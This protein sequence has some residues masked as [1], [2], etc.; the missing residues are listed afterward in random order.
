MIA[1][2]AVAS[3]AVAQ[4]APAPASLDV[5]A[6]PQRL[7]TL[8]DHRRINLYCTGSGG[9]TVFLDGGWES[10]TASWRKVQPELARTMRVCSYDR[11][12]YGFSD[13]GSMPRTADALARDLDAVIN[14]SGEKGPYI[15]VAHSMGSFPARLYATRHPQDVAALILLDPPVEHTQ[16]RYEA[17]RPDAGDAGFVTAAVACS[18]AVLAG[19]TPEP[20][21][22][23]C[24]DAPS[25]SLPPALNAARDA[26]EHSPAFQ[27]T[28]LSEIQAFLTTD[29]DQMNAARRP[30]G[31]LPV[32]VITSGASATDPSFSESQN[33]ALREL[34]WDTQDGLAQLSARPIHR[35]LPGAS[36][37]IPS[38]HPEAVVAA[39]MEARAMITK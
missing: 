19:K 30:L 16:A 36:H 5:Y 1:T 22:D 21:A 20:G 10:T 34:Q 12:G 8:P 17:I 31:A 4:N 3:G 7:I 28:A 29:G 35:L 26:F 9:P 18:Q 32:I 2:L 15:V 13:I 25:P 6:R 39:V 37:F 14:A 38:E 27:Q 23:V 11:A 24:V 33:R